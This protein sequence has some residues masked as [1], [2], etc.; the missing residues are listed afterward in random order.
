MYVCF[1][2]SWDIEGIAQEWSCGEI[3][4][5]GKEA[6]ARADSITLNISLWVVFNCVLKYIY[7]GVVVSDVVDWEELWRMRL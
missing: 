7:V 4:F 6:V 2:C 5:G 1:L 3:E